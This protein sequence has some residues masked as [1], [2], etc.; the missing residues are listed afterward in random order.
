MA[1]LNIYIIYIFFSCLFVQYVLYCVLFVYCLIRISSPSTVQIQHV[2]TFTLVPI[3]PSF[4]SR[5]CGSPSP[6]LCAELENRKTAHSHRLE[7]QFRGEG[8]FKKAFQ[9]GQHPLALFCSF[10]AL[11][12]SRSLRPFSSFEFVVPFFSSTGPLSFLFS[13]R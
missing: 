10:R 2:Q 7:E 13:T 4:R 9:L 11:H 1:P 8:S 6:S 12:L 5:V 3:Q